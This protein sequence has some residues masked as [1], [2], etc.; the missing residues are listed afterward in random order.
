MN[1][2]IAL[3]VVL[4]IVTLGI[5]VFYWAY[6]LNEEIAREAGR[7]PI[8]S[9]GLLILLSIVTFGIFFIYWCYKQGEAID[10]IQANHGQ[11]GG[12]NAVIYLLLGLF[13]GGIITCALA[14]NE[15]NKY[16]SA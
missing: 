15:L 13:T 11:G 16:V 2:N 7:P 3:Y 14:Q 4:C 1:R 8:I 10:T 9:G 12:N 5:F 6:K